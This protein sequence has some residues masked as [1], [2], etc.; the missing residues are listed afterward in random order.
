LHKTS[1]KQTITIKWNA[2][3]WDLGLE[4]G[5]LNFQA[6]HI[7]MY[8]HCIL[9][10]LLNAHEEEDLGNPNN[11]RSISKQFALSLVKRLHIGHCSK[12]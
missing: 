7:V 3:E 1:T 11:K 6:Q 4:S 10:K 12:Q 9:H 8:T 5:Y 2:F